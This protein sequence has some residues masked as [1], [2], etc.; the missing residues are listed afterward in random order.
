MSQYIPYPTGTVT[1]EFD[2]RP[3]SATY[4][5]LNGTITVTTS[6]GR[7]TDLVGAVRS[8]SG[9]KFLAMRLLLDLAVEG[10]APS[11][12]PNLA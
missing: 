9:I 1:I 11:H 4:S 7:K 10:G 8:N 2:G 12:R 3:I 5:V 6:Y